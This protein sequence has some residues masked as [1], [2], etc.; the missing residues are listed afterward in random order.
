MGLKDLRKASGITQK[1]AADLF[2]LKYRTYQNYENG[3]TS[4]SMDMAAEFARYFNCTI[5]DLFDLKDGAEASLSDDERNLI[6]VFRSLDAH[7]KMALISAANGLA[8]NFST[9]S[10]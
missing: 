7:G 1:E 2:G 3:Q 5:G 10:K 8:E 9:D 4:P 6:D